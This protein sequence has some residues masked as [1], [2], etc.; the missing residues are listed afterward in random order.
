MNKKDNNKMPIKYIGLDIKLS[1]EYL[2]KIFT[3]I[4]DAVLCINR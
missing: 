4:F 2:N 1:N 3:K